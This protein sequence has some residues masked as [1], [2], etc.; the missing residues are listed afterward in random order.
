VKVAIVDGYVDEPSC[1]GVPPYISP[2]PRYI[3]GMLNYLKIPSAYFTAEQIRKKPKILENFDL[4]IVIAGAIV[5]GKYL[6]AKPL[7]LEDIVLLP[8]KKVVVGGISL[9][10]DDNERERLNVLDFPFEDELLKILIKL[11]GYK[12]DL[13][14]WSNIN[15]FA[16]LGSEVVKEHVDYP[17]LICEIETYRGCYWGKCSFCVERLHSVR[18]RSPKAVVSEIKS[19]YSHGIRH[20]R[21]GRQ[22]DFFTYLADFSEEVPRPVP[23]K[24][25]AFHEAIWKNCPNIKTL[26]IDNVNPKTVSEHPEESRDVV[27]IVVNYQ[28]PGN[29]AAMGL[30]SADSRVISKNNLCSSVE[31]VEFAVNLI[32]EYGAERGYNGMPKFLPGL[33]F[34]VGLKGETN[35]TFE[36]NY[37]FLLKMFDNG[38]LLRRINIRQ[39]KVLRSTP[40]YVERKGVEA[41]LKKHKKMFIHFKRMVREKIDREMLKKMLPVGTMLKDVRCEVFE[42]GITFARQFGSYPL[43]VGIPGKYKRN[44]LLNVRVIGYGMRSVTAIP[45]VDIMKAS[46]K[47][48]EAIPGISKNLARKIVLERASKDRKEIMDIVRSAS[49]FEKVKIFLK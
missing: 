7:R 42:K 22:T 9:E 32:N 23:E 5:P 30:E 33:N 27:K 18:H 1:L 10:L 49:N 24:L 25:K 34:V 12:E 17:N 45:P 26:H 31:D 15:R 8:G 20:F 40:L 19:L 36:L 46:L 4:S 44:L 29:V 39:V 35:R 41:R 28:T 47:E 48:L 14:F 2:Y 37:E 21:L 6:T 38:L 11:S 43:L 3:K 13:D 16:L